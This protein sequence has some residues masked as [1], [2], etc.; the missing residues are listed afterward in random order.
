MESWEMICVLVHRKTGGGSTSPDRTRTPGP[1]F[2]AAGA[3]RGGSLWVGSPQRGT[4]G[5][6]A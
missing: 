6:R 2:P 5:A 1:A 4:R 3:G